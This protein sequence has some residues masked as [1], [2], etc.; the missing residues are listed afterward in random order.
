MKRLFPLIISLVISLGMAAQRQT[1]KT[2]MV[3]IRLPLWQDHS[4]NLILFSIM[5]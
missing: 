4:Y 5:V 3:L 1:D 2:V